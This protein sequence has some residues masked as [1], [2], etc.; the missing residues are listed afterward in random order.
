VPT[1]PLTKF[2]LHAAG[3]HDGRSSNTVVDRVIS[4]YSSSVKAILFNRRRRETVP[5]S[6]TV[7]LKPQPKALLVAMPTTPEQS[8]LSFAAEEVHILHAICA[9]VGL[10]PVTPRRRK[11]DVLP[12]LAQCHI[13]HFS[14]HGRS[15]RLDPAQ[16]ALLLEDW[17]RDRLTVA[18]LLAL[19]L[20]SAANR[21]PFLA[22]LSACST[23]Q[24]KDGKAWDES[25][26][27]VGACQL[28]GF[29]HVVGTLWEVDDE[30][31]VDM[32]R[33]VYET[34][35][36]RGMTDEAVGLGLHRAARQ[37]RDRWVASSGMARRG[38]DVPAEGGRLH[39]L[40]EGVSSLELAGSR[41]E[42]GSSRNISAL[43]G[44][45]ARLYWVPYVHFGV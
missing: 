45:E 2:P 16:S 44:D 8:P 14:G 9:S 7:S 41:G 3:Y 28:A 30:L 34:M 25:I 1:G 10:K 4:S 24:V 15:S 13:F 21:Q 36:D 11:A 31:C 19:N 22:Y 6:S 18:S 33:G 42:A 27:L 39:E 32:A 43:E 23:G 37:A 17:R 12:H 29:R 20:A 35:R 26:H 5:T 38:G 40:G